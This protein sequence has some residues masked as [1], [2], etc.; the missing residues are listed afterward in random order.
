MKFDSCFFRRA[1]YE[2]RLSIVNVRIS[3][4]NEYFVPT[5]GECRYFLVL[6]RVF[7]IL[8]CDLL[9]LIYS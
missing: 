8:F 7:Y 2:P 6:R 3:D 4:V 9:Q 1:L 5:F